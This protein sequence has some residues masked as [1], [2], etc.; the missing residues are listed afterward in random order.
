MY[1]CLILF[2]F[3]IR[4]I[5]NIKQKHKFNDTGSKELYNEFDSF[6]NCIH[7]IRFFIY[8][9]NKTLIL[10]ILPST[11]WRHYLRLIVQSSLLNW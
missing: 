3:R 10:K 8:K 11:I 1:I 9:Y 2:N 4:V 7:Y 6:N 5:I